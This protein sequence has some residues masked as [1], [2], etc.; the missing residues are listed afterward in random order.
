MF[1]KYKIKRI[2]NYLESRIYYNLDFKF[3]KKSNKQLRKKTQFREKERER[4]RVI[5]K[6]LVINKREKRN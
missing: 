5:I 6:Q 2:Q 4:E 1:D 3:E